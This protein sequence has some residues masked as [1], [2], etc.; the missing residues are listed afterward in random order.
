MTHEIHVMPW[1][2]KHAQLRA[3]QR[4]GGNPTRRA[5]GD[6]VLAIL[7]SAAGLSTA[8]TLLHAAPI[9]E[10]WLINLAGMP[11]KV[12]WCQE[13]AIIRTIYEAESRQVMVRPMRAASW[14]RR[15]E[16]ARATL[17]LVRQAWGDEA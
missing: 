12:I 17:N 10:R 14:G 9:G 6:A 13:H 7:D 2:T 4:L 16:P 8:A 11:V 5:W 3:I 1:V 15:P